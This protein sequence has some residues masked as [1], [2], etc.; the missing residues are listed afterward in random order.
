M[1]ALPAH[2]NDRI[3]VHPAVPAARRVGI[4]PLGSRKRSMKRPRAGPAEKDSHT[5]L[6]RMVEGGLIRGL[7]PLRGKLRGK[8]GHGGRG[9]MRISLGPA[10]TLGQLRSLA[11][12]LLK[13]E[14]SGSH[15]R[16][17][18]AT[19]NRHTRNNVGKMGCDG[20]NSRSWQT[21]GAQSSRCQ[22]IQ[23][24]VDSSNS[25]A[26]SRPAEVEPQTARLTPK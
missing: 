26:C 1:S 10:P 12:R 6:R 19:P 22:R 25:G 23:H 14:G 8:G 13:P 17:K 11:D 21:H 18:T 3:A 16:D 15:G 4:T 5:H 9:R 2:R 20:A 7:P 24:L